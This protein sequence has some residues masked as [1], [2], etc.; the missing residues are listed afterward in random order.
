MVTS[1]FSCVPFRAASAARLTPRDGPP[2]AHE[3]Q[4]N[5]RAWLAILSRNRGWNKPPGLRVNLIRSADESPLHVWMIFAVVVD[6]S[7][8]FQNDASCFLGGNGDVPVAIPCRR[9]VDEDVVVD[10]LDRVA[11]LRAGFER[12]ID[13][14]VH[15]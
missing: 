12:C 8:F 13:Q 11:D 9:S 1:V 7:R 15:R 5:C 3:S 4:R 10:P 2:M 6:R 14:L